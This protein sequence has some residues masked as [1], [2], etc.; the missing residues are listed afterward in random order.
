MA[1]KNMQ[2][3]AIYC[4]SALYKKTKGKKISGSDKKRTMLYA[5]EQ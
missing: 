3:Q 1:S 4:F 5:S 2:Q